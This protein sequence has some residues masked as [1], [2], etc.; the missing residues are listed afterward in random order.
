[1]EEINAALKAGTSP[2]VQLW[3][4]WM[5]IIFL[6]SLIFVWKFKPARWAFAAIVGTGIL[7]S[8][9]WSMTQNV[10]LFGV[11]HLILWTPLAIY[12]WKQVLSSDARAGA[13]AGL[14]SFAHFIWA[15]LLFLTIVISLVF[16]VRDVVLVLTGAK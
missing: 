2:G 11:A 1:M 14:Y 12:L 15:A 3:M 7:V 16:D 10:H 6:L 9:I 13:D 5:G 4:N 8:I